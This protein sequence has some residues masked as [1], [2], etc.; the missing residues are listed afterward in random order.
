MAKRL[1]KDKLID[2]N[3]I[4]EKLTKIKDADIAY[5]TP[6]GKIYLEN[7]PNKFYEL[8]TREVFGYTYCCIKLKNQTRK[9][10]RVHR[11]V[12]LT[13]INNP[14]PNEYNIVG[15]KNNIK[16][17]NRC[18]NLY[19]TNVSENT[20]KAFD[21]KLI[22]N[23]KSWEDSQSISVV[24]LDLN[25]NLIQEYGSI[26]EASRDNNITKTTI[27]IQINHQTKTVPRKK[28]YYRLKS[29]YDIYGFVL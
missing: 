18:E 20:K 22:V 26:G 4:K 6:N 17:D 25:G 2:R 10:F 21:D 13:Y 7:L 14:K 8:K 23:A 24:K 28:F 1:M 19:W 11:L 15:H 16:N 5:I 12:A 27:C 9:N 3:D 29:E